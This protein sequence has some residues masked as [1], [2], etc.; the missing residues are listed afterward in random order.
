MAVARKRHA[1]RSSKQ[2]PKAPLKKVKR[3]NAGCC[4]SGC[5][6]DIICTADDIYEPPQRDDSHFITG[7]DISEFMAPKRIM[8]NAKL[9]RLYELKRRKNER[10]RDQDKERQEYKVDF[11]KGLSNALRKLSFSE[12]LDPLTAQMAP[13]SV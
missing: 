12:P 9:N 3:E 6:A 5:C 7:P 1:P 13:K 11:S 8:P 4:E 10:K 2:N